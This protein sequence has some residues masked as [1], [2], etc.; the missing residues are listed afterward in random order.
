MHFL[1]RRKKCNICKYFSS[2]NCILQKSISMNRLWAVGCMPWAREQRWSIWPAV[3]CTLSWTQG[4][5]LKRALGLSP[6]ARSGWFRFQNLSLYSDLGS[7][8]FFLYLANLADS[9]HMYADLN[10]AFLVDADS[11]PAFHVRSY[12]ER[13]YTYFCWLFCMIFFIGYTSK[14][15]N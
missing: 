4:F 14:L 6:S 13:H 2:G 1:L 9:R 10:S 3:L 15:I 11:V 5:L 7:G 12:I 8:R